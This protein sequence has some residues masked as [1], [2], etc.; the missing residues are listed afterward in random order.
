MFSAV[1]LN[2]A[3]RNVGTQAQGAPTPRYATVQAAVNAAATGD[4]IVI[5][6]NTTETGY[7]DVNGK[8][9]TIRSNN[10]TVRTVTVSGNNTTAP[11]TNFTR[12]KNAPN[13]GGF[14]DGR[15]FLF[16]IR[17]GAKVTVNGSITF[18]G[19]QRT[20]S[21]FYVS[22]TGSEL[23]IDG[24]VTITKGYGTIIES[25]EDDVRLIGDANEKFIRFGGGISVVKG[26][27]LTV[28][29]GTITGNQANQGG[30]IFIHKSDAVINAGGKI[31]ENTVVRSDCYNASGV[32]VDPS[33]YAGDVFI[34][35]PFGGGILLRGWVADDEGHL[36]INGGEVSKNYIL[37]TK[38]SNWDNKYV[39]G[40][41]IFS[42]CGIVVL[43]DAKIKENAGFP[44]KTDKETDSYIAKNNG[45]GLACHGGTIT[46]TGDT[47]FDGNKASR[48][49]AISLSHEAVLIADGTTFTKNFGVTMAGAVYCDSKDDADAKASTFTIK[50]STFT[51]NETLENGGAMN[52]QNCESTSLLEN[53][54]FT[55]N[56]AV[57]W[58]GAIF[59]NDSSHP[60][61]TINNVN[62]SGNILTKR[63]MSKFIQVHADET[64]GGE[65]KGGTI[66]LKGEIDTPAG[67]DISIF[68]ETY[69]SKGGSL[70]VPDGQ[71]IEVYVQD[72]KEN[73]IDVYHG[74]DVLVSKTGST[75]IESDLDLFNVTIPNFTD[76]KYGYYITAKYDANG[77]NSTGTSHKDVIELQTTASIIIERSNL[78]DG[79][80]AIYEVRNGSTSGDL[81]YT[82]QLTGGVDE[83]KP[84]S[85]QIVF[86]EPGDYAVT[87]N[88]WDWSYN[89][90]SEGLT[91]TKNVPA[92]SPVKGTSGTFTGPITFSFNGAKDTTIAPY[93][94]DVDVK[95]IPKQ[96]SGGGMEEGHNID[97]L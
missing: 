40:A 89:N 47:V 66:L 83:S 91:K 31:T 18:D 85:R 2:A 14:E 90:G 44:G 25:A 72:F 20:L 48:G 87:E 71:K 57:W 45:G 92:A 26:A 7:I 16:Y 60:S 35:Y 73:D 56:K 61:F 93:D 52:I 41:G 4:V 95:D 79:E 13:G 63:A 15:A 75:V 22:G 5:Y 62:A 28:E 38:F 96:G 94:E 88:T 59:L 21:L 78:K 30:G 19:N 1:T 65:H 10:T 42:D 70:S 33:G 51:E 97:D 9:L 29:N 55:E 67:Q 6:G 54:T 77:N 46:I 17:G 24:N 36:T 43:N 37:D 81:L 84:A 8:N 82:V 3:N 27:T 23:T 11:L 76:P 80:S 39:S 49:G 69:L 58:G 68:G 50:N 74:R 34:N 86:L 12:P 32:V 64:F 53:C